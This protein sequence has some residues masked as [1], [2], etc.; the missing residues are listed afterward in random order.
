MWDKRLSVV[1]RRAPP[2]RCLQHEAPSDWRGDECCSQ[3]CSHLEKPAEEHPGP[4]WWP[5]LAAGKPKDPPLTFSYHDS[6]FGACIT[7]FPPYLIMLSTVVRGPVQYYTLLFFNF[8]SL[9]KEKIP[10]GTQVI[11]F[12]RGECVGSGPIWAVC[13]HRQW[14]CVC[15]CITQQHRE[16]QYQGI[17]SERYFVQLQMSKLFNVILYFCVRVLGLCWQILFMSSEKPASSIS[18]LAASASLVLL[19]SSQCKH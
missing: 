4:V 15:L 1:C 14:V 16:K 18:S 10:L 8:S 11:T 12:F 2:G 9:G 6:P 3:W 17:W 19:A 13:G 5:G 7:I